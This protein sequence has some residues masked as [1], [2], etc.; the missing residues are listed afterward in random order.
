MNNKNELP[1]EGYI[2]LKQLIGADKGLTPIIPVCAATIWNWVKS[3]RL[4]PPVKLSPSV[5]AWRVSDIRD[6]LEL[7]GER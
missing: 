4:P 6:V 7:G 5:T 3:G 2:R 1:R